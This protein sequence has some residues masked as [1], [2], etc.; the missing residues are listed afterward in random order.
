MDQRKGRTGRTCDGKYT[1]LL[2]S[3][4]DTP[5]DFST[6]FYFNS[7]EVVK[8]WSPEA[9]RPRD[10]RKGCLGGLPAGYDSLLRDGNWSAILY[11]V[12]FYENR[13]DVNKTRANYQSARKFPDRADIAYV[14][15][16]HQN[17]CFADLHVVESFLGKFRIDG[18]DGNCWLPKGTNVYVETFAQPVPAHLQDVD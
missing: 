13:G 18:Q 5:W 4:N 3:F 16:K 12:F 7:W 11:L 1:R 14:V 8:A 15:G 2:A 10:K 9:E 17:R 6:P